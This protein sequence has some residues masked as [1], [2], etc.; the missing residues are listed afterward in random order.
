MRQIKSWLPPELIRIGRH[1]LGYGG[2]YRGQYNTWEEAAAQADG[3]DTDAILKRVLEATLAVRDGKAAFERDGVLFAKAQDRYPML[4][5]LMHAAAAAS[6]G[7]L[8]VLDVGGAL[9]SA[10]FQCKPWLQGLAPVQWC[11]MEQPHYA[12]TGKAQ[13]EDGVLC[14]A[15]SAEDAA[16]HGPFDIVIFSSV[17]QFIQNISEFLRPI[18]ALKPAYILIDRT[19]VIAGNI[20]RIS[21]QKQGIGSRVVHSSYPLRLMTEQS[22]YSAIGPDYRLFSQFD[23]LDEPM[24]GIGWRAD[25]RGFLFKR[26]YNG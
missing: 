21:I 2:Y 9:G 25:F 18:L 26:E 24:G 7:H 3:Y 19:P 4:A 17:L 10:Y 22:I 20:D 8:R 15:G 5:S 1:I 23:A 13:L 6:P 16:R 11:V 12:A 14:F